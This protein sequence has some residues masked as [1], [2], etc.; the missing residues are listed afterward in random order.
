MAPLST[1]AMR[2]AYLT[3]LVVAFFLP[4]KLDCSFPGQSCAPYTSLGLRCTR[5]D[6]EPWGFYLLERAFDRDIGFAYAHYETCH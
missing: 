5:Q 4:K 3:A 6:L 2:W 1:R